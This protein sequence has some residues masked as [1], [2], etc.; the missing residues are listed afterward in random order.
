MGGVLRSILHNIQGVGLMAIPIAGVPGKAAV[1]AEWREQAGE[2]FPGP[3][4]IAE[5]VGSMYDDGLI[6]L[7]EAPGIMLS[8][9][10]GW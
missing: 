7:E 8:K 9:L 4:S 1:L 6:S 2:D 10:N 3:A 5:D